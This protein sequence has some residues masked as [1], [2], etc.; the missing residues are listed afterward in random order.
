MALPRVGEWS[1]CASSCAE[2]FLVSVPQNGRGRACEYELGAKRQC[3]GG[4]CS[5]HSDICGPGYN[6]CPSCCDADADCEC[7]QECPDH[8][9]AWERGCSVARND[10]GDGGWPVML[11]LV[12]GIVVLLAVLAAAILLRFAAGDESWAFRFCRSGPTRG[13]LGGLSVPPANRLCKI[14]GLLYARVQGA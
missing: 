1:R 12:I 10:A 5:S 14:M 6:V 3:T 2:T 8:P 4:L 7:D 13:R 11:W 9:E